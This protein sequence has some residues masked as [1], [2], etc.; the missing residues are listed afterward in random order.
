M[1]DFYKTLNR[2]GIFSDNIIE[3]IK[4]KKGSY[5][6]RNSKGIMRENLVKAVNDDLSHEL[7]NINSDVH[8]IWG[9]EDKEVPINIAKEANKKIKKSNL[10]IL[11]GQGHNPLNSSYLEIV[12]I[13]NTQ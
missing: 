13:I 2:L 9:S 11:E 10:H 6:Y 5:D 12:N 8:L 1:L 3:N 7:E 4:K